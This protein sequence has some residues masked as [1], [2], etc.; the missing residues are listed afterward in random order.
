MFNMADSPPSFSASAGGSYELATR[1]MSSIETYVARFATAKLGLCALW[2]SMARD[3]LS[4]ESF[5]TDDPL[6]TYMVVQGACTRDVYRIR[7]EDAHPEHVETL[8]RAVMFLLR[9]WEHPVMLGDVDKVLV[10]TL[11]QLRE[12]KVLCSR[13]IDEI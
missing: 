5:Y 13:P 1:K 9:N 6:A 7:T 12:F 4:L 10:R 8:I 3:N 2:A 11:R